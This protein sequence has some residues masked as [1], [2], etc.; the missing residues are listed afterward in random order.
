MQSFFAKSAVLP[1]G[2]HNNVRID[3][4]NGFIVAISPNIENFSAEAAA[5]IVPGFVDIHGHG[6][7]G[8]DD[9][10]KYWLSDFTTEM[11]PKAKMRSRSLTRSVHAI[12]V[13]TMRVYVR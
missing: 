8:S 7:G 2:I 5:V 9:L 3:V 11:L 10:M 4:E 13:L 12:P 1:S 6:F